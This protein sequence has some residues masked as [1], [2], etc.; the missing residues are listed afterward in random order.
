MKL[1]TV[2]VPLT[3]RINTLE[4]EH[5]KAGDKGW[6]TLLNQSLFHAVN[7]GA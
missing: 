4:I 2:K 1:N 5:L 6:Q 3:L 7:C